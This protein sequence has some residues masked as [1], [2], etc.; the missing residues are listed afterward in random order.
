MNRTK[1]SQSVRRANK[2]AIAAL[3]LGHFVND[4]YTSNIYPLLPLLALKLHLT[5]LEVFSL[6]PTLAITAAVMQPVFGFII[7]RVSQRLFAIIGPAVTG[8]CISLIG[9]APSYG[10]L[11]ALLF[12]G[13]MGAGTFHPQAVSLV[14]RA[15]G[16]KRR[17]GV[18]LFTAA[19]TFGFALG[20]FIAASVIGTGDISR[21]T[22]LMG[23]GVVAAI[24]VYCYCPVGDHLGTDARPKAGLRG[25]LRALGAVRGPL[26][27]LYL[28]SLSRAMV[29]MLVNNYVPF[30]LSNEG[31]TIEAIGTILTA[32]LLAGAMGSLAGG[33]LSEKLGGHLLSVISGG[34]AALLLGL[35]FLS[36]GPL[37]ILLMTLGS[38]ALM[39]MM[40]VN[41]AWAQELVPRETSTVSAL[42]MG[43]VWGIASVAV[44][45][46]GPLVTSWGFRP[47]LVV[48]SLLPF[49]T[50]ILALR[51]P[52]A[53]DATSLEE[54]PVEFVQSTESI[55]ADDETVEI[56]A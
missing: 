45:A 13:G 25:L 26:F 31:Y 37:G 32:F 50:G 46:A 12:I 33:T 43:L 10:I 8:C 16:L 4:T 42:L 22:Y 20:P 11:L 9:V 44:P 18:S 39:T 56:N 40:P 2:P 24:F 53:D 55:C 7:E 51:L 27:I 19:G 47:I 3:S 5:E 41:I 34:A 29:H 6:V 17:V 36:H 15:S 30:I 21:T 14:A 38:F 35:S 23:G 49:A 28:I 1:Q 52:R 48:A 54:R